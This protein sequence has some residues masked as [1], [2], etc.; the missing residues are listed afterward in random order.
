MRSGEM[1]LLPMYV[2]RSRLSADAPHNSF[3]ESESVKPAQHFPHILNFIM[4]STHVQDSSMVRLT[5]VS[6]LIASINRIKKS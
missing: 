2:H 5:R 4:N 3:L 6:H 1:T